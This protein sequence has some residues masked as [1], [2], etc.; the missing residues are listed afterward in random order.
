VFLYPWDKREPGKPG[1]LRLMYEANP[2]A[3][4]VEQAGGAA[5][6]GREPHPGHPADQAARAP[7]SV[8]LG[9]KNEVERVTSCY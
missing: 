4:L 9:S 7:V 5:T 2:M 8:V 3:W 6:N 1:K